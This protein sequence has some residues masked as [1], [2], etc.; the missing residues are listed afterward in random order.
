MARFRNRATLNRGTECNLAR[1]GVPSFAITPKLRAWERT[2]NGEAWFPN[3][4]EMQV[5]LSEFK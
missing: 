3:F 2:L 4:G 1:K 5:Y